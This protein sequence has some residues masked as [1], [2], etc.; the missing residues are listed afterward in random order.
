[1][2]YQKHYDALIERARSRGR[3]ENK[4]RHHVI[5]RCLGG[6]NEA[7]NIVELT[8]EEHFLAHQLLVKIFQK[9]KKLVYAAMAMTIGNRS[10]GRATNKMYGWLK[11]KFSENH[12]SKDEIV[13]AK[14]LAHKGTVARNKRNSERLKGDENPSK[15][16]DFAAKITSNENWK[17]SHPIALQA[18]REASLGNNWGSLAVHSEEGRRVRA[19]APHL[20]MASAIGVA[21]RTGAPFS[22]VKL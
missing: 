3:I 14:I 4:E 5:P 9:E 2:N 13:M 12:P 21:V 7:N 18:A 17:K 10:M 22:R 20:R 16:P 19:K 6:S 15:S 11:R 8:Q 1:M